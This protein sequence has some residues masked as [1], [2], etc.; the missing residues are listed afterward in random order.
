MDKLTKGALLSTIALLII[1]SLYL[2]KGWLEG[3]ADMEEEKQKL[4]DL[5]DQLLDERK[6]NDA[7]DAKLAGQIEALRKQM[8]TK[9]AAA[10]G[11]VAA[12]QAEKEMLEA[13][14]K[15][16]VEGIRSNEDEVVELTEEQRKISEAPAIAKIAAVDGGKGF[17]IIDAGSA[18]GLESGVRF[19]IRREVFIVGEIVID[20]VTGEGNSIANIDGD[21]IPQGLSIKIGDDVVSHPIY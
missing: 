16:I 21:K 18:K 8:S 19:N 11:K 3:R 17:V 14:N 1:V 5:T 9:S 2:G 13:E 12:L 7:A 20:K 15:A 6:D 10:E 4:D